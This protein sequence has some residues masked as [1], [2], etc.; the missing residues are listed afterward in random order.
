MKTARLVLDFT[1]KSR[2]TTQKNWKP[3]QN[4][5][6]CCTTEDFFLTSIY[7]QIQFFVSVRKGQL[8][9]QEK[10]SSVRSHETH[11]IYTAFKDS[12][13]SRV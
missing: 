7:I 9:E 12:S 8:P 10:H 3:H 5:L 2:K 13:I 11:A 4:I 6:Q 1:G